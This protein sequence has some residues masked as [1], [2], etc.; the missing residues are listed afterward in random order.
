MAVDYVLAHPGRYLATEAEK[1]DCFHRELGIGMDCLPVKIYHSHAKA[2]PVRRYFVDKFPISVSEEPLV[3][4]AY[5]DEGEIATPAFETYSARYARLFM[6]LDRF[7]VAFV[8]IKEQRFLEAQRTFQRFLP[9]LNPGE[10]K[11]M[12]RLL[13]WL[14][15]ENLVRREQYDVVSLG[16]LEDLRALRKEFQGVGYERLMDI[17]SQGGEQAVRHNLTGKSHFPASTEPELVLCHL[18]HNYAF[19]HTAKP[20]LRNGNP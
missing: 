15:L 14:R 7:R 3:S 9:Y 2:S 18:P 19:L 1:H 13:T 4:F 5:I 20:R 6:V 12:D 17:W 11:D 8:T 16:D 10:H